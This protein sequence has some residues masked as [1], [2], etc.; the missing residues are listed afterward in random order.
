M[1]K[2]K[3]AKAKFGFAPHGIVEL[4][5]WKNKIEPV[6]LLEAHSKRYTPIHLIDSRPVMTTYDFGP[7]KLVSRNYSK[8]NDFPYLWRNLLDLVKK[9]SAIA[10]MPVAR[11][12]YKDGTA[13]I[14]SI[15]RKNTRELSGFL[16]DEK[17]KYELKEK[18]LV[19]AAK[20]LAKLHA[21][22]Y[23]HNHAHLGNFVTHPSGETHLVDYTS[24]NKIGEKGGK[25][26]LNALFTKT[27]EVLGLRFSTVPAS[28]DIRRLFEQDIIGKMQQVYEKQ[29]ETS[30]RT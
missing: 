4:T 9:K 22:G 16:T 23:T 29:F 13:E 27:R 5:Y 25:N 30:K 7:Y 3:W 20:S 28:K 1:A 21:A 11:I 2:L 18:A 24:I 15:W 14:I 12:C 6:K 19:T 17:I 26:D 10:E 8:Q